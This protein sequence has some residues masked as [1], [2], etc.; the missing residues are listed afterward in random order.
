MCSSDLAKQ[1]LALPLTVNGKTDRQALLR[2]SEGQRVASSAHAPARNRMEETVSGIWQ[3]VLGFQQFGIHDNFFDLG[4]H[5]L[6]MV[7]VRSR[8]R[9][10]LQKEV[11][12]VELFRNPT[13]ALLAQYLAQ[14]E[15][16]TPSLQIAQTRAG[17][18]IAAARR[19]AEPV[20]SS[21]NE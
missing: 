2:A 14:G 10:A 13:I 20:R 6:S 11:P 17:R 5:S 18:R 9:E 21:P 19:G 16:R 4:G 8:L 12:M 15:A 3:E 1:S 7:Q